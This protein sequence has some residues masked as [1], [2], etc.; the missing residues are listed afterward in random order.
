L[1]QIKKLSVEE[2]SRAVNRKQAEKIVAHLRNGDTR[3][4]ETS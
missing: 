4:G 1:A 3:A 2:I